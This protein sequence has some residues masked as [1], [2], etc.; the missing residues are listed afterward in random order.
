MKAFKFSAF[1][2]FSVILFSPVFTSCLNNEDDG[3]TFTSSYSG[4]ALI[5]YYGGKPVVQTVSIQSYPNLLYSSQLDKLTDPA[6]TPVYVSFLYN[7]YNQS[8]T[9]YITG[10]FQGFNWLPEYGISEKDTEKDDYILPI[11]FS[12]DQQNATDRIENTW[13]LFPGI[14]DQADQVTDFELI[15]LPAETENNKFTFYLKAKITTSGSGANQST[16]S[17]IAVNLNDFIDREG[18]LKNRDQITYD[19]KYASSIDENGNVTYK[20]LFSDNV[21]WEKN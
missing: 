16:T 13:F 20:T 4:P 6:G 11:S 9:Q 21:L 8:S 1:S 3:D 12:A 17:P 10:S 2:F 5:Q 14:S 15:Y 18:I 7:D 19:L